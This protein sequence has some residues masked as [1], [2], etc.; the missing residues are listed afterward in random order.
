MTVFP[1]QV[2]ERLS[3]QFFCQI[4]GLCLVDPHPGGV[5]AEA[6]VHPQI[7]RQMEIASGI[8]RRQ[9]DVFQELAKR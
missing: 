1:D 2:D 4:P 3:A 9:A 5:Q 6:L 7:E 8:L